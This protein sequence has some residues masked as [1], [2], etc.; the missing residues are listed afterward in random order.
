[1]HEQNFLPSTKV[2]SGIMGPNSPARF[3][4]NYIS[5]YFS[6]AKVLESTPPTAYHFTHTCVVECYT[7]SHNYHTFVPP[8]RNNTKAYLLLKVVQYEF[9]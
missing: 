4:Q 1:M 2:V 3:A 5:P 8:R 9:P 7:F 6:F